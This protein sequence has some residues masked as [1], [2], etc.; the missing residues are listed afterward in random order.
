MIST[1]LW[2]LSLEFAKSGNLPMQLMKKRNPVKAHNS[3]KKIAN[4]L[5]DNGIKT[6]VTSNILKSN[7]YEEVI[8][9]PCYYLL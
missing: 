6:A 8:A 9:N 1:Q 2:S 3:I 5:V 4:F 7:K